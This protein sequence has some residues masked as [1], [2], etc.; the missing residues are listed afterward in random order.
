MPDEHGLYLSD[1]LPTSYHCVHDTGVFPSDTVAIWGAGPIGIMCA[2][3]AKQAKASRIIMVDAN[4]RLKYAKQKLPWVETLD[5]NALPRGRTVTAEIQ[6]RVPGGVDVALECVGGEYAK[7]WAH[8]FELA[9][10]METDSSEILNEMITSVR[11]FGRCG[12]IGAYVGFT[13]HFNI[14]ALMERGIRFI[15]NGQTPVHKYWE[16]LLGM[17]QR[18]E[19]DPGVMISHRIDMEDFAKLYEEF[20]KRSEE[21]GLMKVFVQT[22]HSFPPAPGTPELVKL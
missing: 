21:L 9:L 5:Y 10:G 22:K 2:V 1:V 18:K 11:K 7:G 19:V 15:G 8:Y 16:E 3:F 12:V 14:G 13:N 4:W 6:E 17:I 20:D